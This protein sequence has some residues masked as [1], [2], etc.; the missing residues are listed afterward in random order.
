MSS[1]SGSSVV[2]IRKF[3]SV[4]NLG[5]R[6]NSLPGVRPDEKFCLEIPLEL[7]EEVDAGQLFE[8]IC[9]PLTSDTPKAPTSRNDPITCRHKLKL[10]DDAP[11]NE[12]I[13][14][15]ESAG[16]LLNNVTNFAGSATRTPLSVAGFSLLTLL[17]TPPPDAGGGNFLLY[18]EGGNLCGITKHISSVLFGATDD[19]PQLVNT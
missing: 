8:R 2:P 19:A 12:I 10:K 3:I 7:V 15:F 5:W 14:V 18:M 6:T 4:C 1:S 17:P 16:H 11:R 13:S 9:V